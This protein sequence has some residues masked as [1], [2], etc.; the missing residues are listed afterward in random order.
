MPVL[1]GSLGVAKGLSLVRFLSISVSDNIFFPLLWST[2]LLGDL[3]LVGNTF[4][5]TRGRL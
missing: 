1:E 5:N 3:S 4:F 2:A